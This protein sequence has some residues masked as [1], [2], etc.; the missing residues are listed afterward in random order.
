MG[1]S[2]VLV[3]EGVIRGAE[4]VVR[5]GGRWRWAP[6]PGTTPEPASLDEVRGALGAEA[7]AAESGSWLSTSGPGPLDADAVV[8]PAWAW[9]GRIVEGGVEV[10]DAAGERLVLDPVDLALV[11]AVDPARRAAD[12]VARAGDPADGRRRLARLVAAGKLH[13]LAPGETPPAPPAAPDEIPVGDDV[14]ALPP[15]DALV[16]TGTTGG[17]GGDGR[18]PVLAIWQERVGPALST[19]M[20]TAAARSWQD[21]ALGA[22]YDIHRPLT[23]AEALHALAGRRGPAVLLCSNYVWSLDHNLEV[24]R[25]A[26]ALCPELVVVHGGPSTPKY[27]TDAVRFLDDHDGIAHV[28]VQGEGEVAVCRILEALRSSLPELDTAALAAIPGLTFRDPADGRVVRTGPPE[29]IA[30]LDSLPSPYL[31]GEFDDL[32]P[33]AFHFAASVETT[34]GC[35]YGCT[36]CDWGSATLA[37]LRKFDVDRVLSEVEWAARR[38]IAAV[39][40]CDANFGITARDIEVARGLADVGRRHGA[41]RI[42]AFTPP[43]NTTRHLTQIL[44]E[45][46]DAGFLVSTAISLQTTDEATLA[47]V[48]RSN[49]ATEHYLALAADLRRRGLPLTGDLLIGLPGQTYESYRADL[50]F[51]LDHQIAPRSW[52]LRSLPNAPMSEPGYRRRFAIRTGP[53]RVVLSTSTMSEDDRDRMLSLRK[54]QVIADQY[55]VLAHLLRFLQWDHG[56]AMSTVLDRVRAL[57]DDDP[58]RYPLVNWLF[59]YFDLHATAP[60]GWQAFYDEIGR[61]LAA[62][63]GVDPTASDVATVLTVQ[64]ALMPFPGRTFPTGVELAHDHVAYH[65]DATAGLYDDGRAGGPPRPLTAYPPATL[66]ITGDPLGLCRGGL[67]FAG[68]PRDESLLG[69][70]WLGVGSSHELASPLT[71]VPAQRRH[72]ELAAR[73]AGL[74]PVGITLGGDAAVA[75][76]TGSARA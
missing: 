63:L 76:T 26:K 36:F 18:V 42:V 64:A 75:A 55:G 10:E 17:D 52:S 59:S 35:P 4:L 8:V 69:Q 15:I 27:D 53:D 30:D 60:V 45:V 74:E 72:L 43:K 11:D 40:F 32:D 44:D 14:D 22:A 73:E 28:L 5:D 62:E 54:V 70:F 38:G 29:R 46:L 58:S 9:V 68:D 37:R 31:T 2:E 49:I 56:L 24:A 13:V 51:F 3:R 41:P 7:G 39:Q 25:R 33:S 16:H 66:E 12:V 47:A 61:F 1:A 48:D 34:R 21:G 65:R 57:V 71:R 20:L 23:G 19:G 6:V 50:Q 67:H